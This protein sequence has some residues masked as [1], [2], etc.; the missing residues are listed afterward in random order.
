MQDR[1]IPAGNA[2][3]IWYVTRDASDP[4]TLYSPVYSVIPNPTPE[5]WTAVCWVGVAGS[6]PLS[7]MWTKIPLWHN[8]LRGR[9]SRIGESKGF[10]SVNSHPFQNKCFHCR[11]EVVTAWRK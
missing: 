8:W 4:N 7:A 1:I 5:S 3:D 11:W 2:D 9:K 6:P 10:L